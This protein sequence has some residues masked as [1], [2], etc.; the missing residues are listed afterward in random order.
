MSPCCLSAREPGPNAAELEKAVAGLKA[1]GRQCA[2][3]LMRQIHLS[4]L[5]PV[6]TELFLVIILVGLNLFTI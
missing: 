5:S 3:G 6:G 1:V 2:A 4:R